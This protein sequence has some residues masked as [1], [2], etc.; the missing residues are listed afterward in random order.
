[1]MTP[2][3][4]KAIADALTIKE[5]AAQ[6]AR[7]TRSGAALMPFVA[8]ATVGAAINWF[9]NGKLAPGLMFGALAGGVI[10]SVVLLYKVI[11][12]IRNRGAH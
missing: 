12:K 6:A 1:M 2:E 7:S 11:Q 5:P 10:S 8:G 3:H 4:A 9:I